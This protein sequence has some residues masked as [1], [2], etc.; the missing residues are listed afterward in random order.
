MISAPF[1][2]FRMLG[3]LGSHHVPTKTTGM[4]PQLS[5]VVFVSR[6]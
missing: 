4:N 2:S 6:L 5:E 3:R 1:V